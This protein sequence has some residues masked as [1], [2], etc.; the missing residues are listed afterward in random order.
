MQKRN[1]AIRSGQTVIRELSQWMSG[2]I[3]MAGM[4]T[5]EEVGRDKDIQ[6]AFINAMKLMNGAKIS[7]RRKKLAK[8]DRNNIYVLDSDKG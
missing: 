7:D 2:R 6:Q 5:A 4:N 3:H 8:K 1:Y